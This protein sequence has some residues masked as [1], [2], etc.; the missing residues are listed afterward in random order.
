MGPSD[1]Q[2]KILMGPRALG[3]GPIT[4]ILLIGKTK[5]RPQVAGS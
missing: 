2:A 3:I 4:E 1:P 5:M